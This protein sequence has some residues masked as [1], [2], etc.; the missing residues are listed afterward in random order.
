MFQKQGVPGQVRYLL[1]LIPIYVSLEQGILNFLDRIDGSFE[2]AG[3]PPKGDM[4][5]KLQKWVD[6]QQDQE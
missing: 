5:R 2:L 4:A 3:V 6:Q 1:K